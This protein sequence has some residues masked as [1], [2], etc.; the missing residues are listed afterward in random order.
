MLSDCLMSH[1]G[2]LFLHEP[3][4]FLLDSDQ[5]I[6]LYCSFNF[7]SFLIPVLHLDLIE[8]WVVVNDQTKIGK[9]VHG[10]VWCGSP[11]LVWV[12][13]AASPFWLEPTA[14]VRMLA[15]WNW[16]GGM[17]SKVRCSAPSMMVGRS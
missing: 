17:V 2:F 5:F 4:Y 6:L 16:T 7:L 8:L 9:G 14:L 12:E 13:L 11:P 3:L 10:N 15:G 1:D